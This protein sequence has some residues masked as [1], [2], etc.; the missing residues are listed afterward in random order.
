MQSAHQVSVDIRRLDGST[1]ERTIDCVSE[2][3]PRDNLIARAL[4][5]TPEDYRPIA[6]RACRAAL[7][8]DMGLITVDGATSEV[9]GF[10]FCLDLVDHFAAVEAMAR[11]GDERLRAWS[12]LHARL[13]GAY[14]ERFGRPR[15]HGEVLYFSI[16]ALSPRI[17]GRG[18]TPE[19]SYRAGIAF[20]VQRGYREIVG[21]AT[22]PR[23][24]KLLGMLVG[25]TWT[26]ELA[27]AELSDPR[28][29]ALEHSAHIFAQTIPE[30]ASSGADALFRR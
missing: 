8:A 15:G 16:G 17:R 27:F 2:L 25:V 3:Y 18:L 13:L 23:T 10:I 7:A 24:V 11:H 6:E 29:R 19:L 1:L 20:G 30:D 28:L 22:H 21:V 4:G 9:L 12:E 5:F 14:E 26:S